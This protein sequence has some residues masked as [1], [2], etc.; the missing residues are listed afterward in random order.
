MDEIIMRTSRAM[1]SHPRLRMLALLAQGEHTPT[2]LAKTL[3]LPLYGVSQHLHILFT[4]SLITRRRSGAM[5]Y[6]RMGS[7][8]RVT[9]FSG[10]LVAWLGSLLNTPSTPEKKHSG[11]A[12]VRDVPAETAEVLHRTIFEAATAFTDLRRLQLLRYLARRQGA[13]AQEVGAVLSMSPQAISRHV[14]KLVRRGYVQTHRLGHRVVYSSSPTFKT[15]IHRRLREI[16][17]AAW[18]QRQASAFMVDSRRSPGR[19]SKGTA[20]SGETAQK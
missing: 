4:A 16:I 6:C 5:N 18:A 14:R 17:E 7:P 2:Q 8:Y 10:K 11:L 15:P 13:D 19:K 12:Q 3:R 20:R 9:T 1:A